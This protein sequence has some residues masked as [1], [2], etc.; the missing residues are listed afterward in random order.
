MVKGLHSIIKNVSLLYFHNKVKL[1]SVED[2]L[3]FNTD[4]IIFSI[5]YVKLNH[6][7]FAKQMNH[8]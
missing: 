5:Q 2:L 7:Q 6:I 4:K 8:H 1:S 3:L